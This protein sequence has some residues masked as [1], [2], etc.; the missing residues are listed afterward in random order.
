MSDYNPRTVIATQR[1]VLRLAARILGKQ[2]NKD[3]LLTDGRSLWTVR[4][5]LDHM[6]QAAAIKVDYGRKRTK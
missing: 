1:R 4:E 3:T 5:I 6:R 2:F